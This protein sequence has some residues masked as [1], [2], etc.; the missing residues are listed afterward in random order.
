MDIQVRENNSNAN[1][2]FKISARDSREAIYEEYQNQ[3][4]VFRILYNKDVPKTEDISQLHRHKVCACLSIAIIK[5]RP[6][7]VRDGFPDDE[8]FKLSEVPSFNEQL[9][10]S[11]G[12]SLLRAYILADGSESDRRKYFEEPDFYVPESFKHVGSKPYGFDTLVTWSLSDANI[13]NGLSAPLLADF[14]FVLDRYHELQCK[15]KELNERLVA[16]EEKG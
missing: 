13:L 2:L 10:L 11:A 5:S 1:S 4:S 16:A 14:Y 12:L 9:A 15:Y 7:Y 6:L 8:K 3:K